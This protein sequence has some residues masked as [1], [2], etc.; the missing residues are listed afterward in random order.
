MLTRSNLGT[1]TA[2]EKL[3]RSSAPLPSLDG[4][5]LILVSDY[6]GDH[7]S[8]RFLAYS[9]VVT[10]VQGLLAFHLEMQRIRDRHRTRRRISY[11]HLTDRQTAALL[12]EFLEAA[13]AIQGV[14][15]TLAVSKN[16]DLLAD[17]QERDFFPETWKPHVRKTAILIAHMAAFLIAGLSRPMQ[18]VLWI[19]DQDN[20][21]AR[22]DQLSV[23]T[24][25]VA[26][27][28]SHVVAHDLG[29][30]R[31]GTTALDP[32]DLQL[33]DLASLS[34]LLAGSHVE[35]LTKNVVQP[36]G[37]TVPATD[38]SAKARM[39]LGYGL[40]RNAEL[41]RLSFVIRRTGG[42]TVTSKLAIH[43]DFEPTPKLWRP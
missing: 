19:T 24:E 30:L 39:T 8:S 26:R 16:I 5:P 12:P 40:D 7:S 32:G 23:L 37:L 35:L 13:N 31:C 14:G 15:F 34:D 36:V 6:A 29:N 22:P 11:K 9:F 43:S 3:I 38:L 18:D 1:F 28:S 4:S 21:A 25:A 41:V 17:D 2:I 42:K 27:A 33:E 10:D 20:I